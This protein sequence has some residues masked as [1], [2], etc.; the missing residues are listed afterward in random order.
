MH[1]EMQIEP[2][3]RKVVWGARGRMTVALTGANGPEIMLPGR[4]SIAR[5]IMEEWYG[6]AI[7]DGQ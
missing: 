2:N 7:P 1:A 5:A 3:R 4:T 6:G